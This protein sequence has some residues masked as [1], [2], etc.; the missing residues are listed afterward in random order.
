MGHFFATTAFKSSDESSIAD[1]I[2]Q[3]SKQY[4]VKARI[5]DKVK[6]P[7]EKTH[8][9]IFPPTNGWCV[10]IWPNYFNIHD[11]PLANFIS[12]SLKIL[13]S[14]VNVYDGDYW[15]HY[16]FENGKKIDN[17]CSIPDYWAEN[18]TEAQELISRKNGTPELVAECIGINKEKIEGYFQPLIEEKEY[19]KVHLNDRSN[20]DDFWV[21]TDFWSQL[22]IKYP[23]DTASFKLIVDL[24]KKFDTKL[25]Q[26]D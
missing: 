14:T 3:Y 6:Q 8:G 4:D 7:N 20:L 16:L 26:I 21:F 19:G 9:I 5:L 24:T 18:E 13:V 17:Y 11:V 23:E 15:C 2:V 12:E 10:V 22:G 1:A 25:P